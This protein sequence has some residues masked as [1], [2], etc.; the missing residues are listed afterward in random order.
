MEV[1]RNWQSIRKLT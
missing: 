1:N